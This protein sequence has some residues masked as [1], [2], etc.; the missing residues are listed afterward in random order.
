MKALLKGQALEGEVLLIEDTFTRSDGG[1]GSTE[2]GSLG[3]LA[4]QGS[5]SNFAVAT[6]AGQPN[7]ATNSSGLIYVDVPAGID[8]RVEANITMVANDAFNLGQLGVFARGN[9]SSRGVTVNMRQTVTGYRPQLHLPGGYNSGDYGSP[10]NAGGLISLTVI[11]DDWSA[12]FSNGSTGPHT[13]STN[14]SE[15]R[16]GI[17]WKMSNS[18]DVLRC[19]DFR[20]YQIL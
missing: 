11:G 7:G 10:S 18:S 8:L 20:V 9:S 17:A 14:H 16:V 5:T 6:N 3:P 13:D 15:T 4:W 2:A 19:L 12:S 1:V